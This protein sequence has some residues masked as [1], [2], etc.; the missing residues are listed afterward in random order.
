MHIESP[1]LLESVQKSQSF[2]PIGRAR[3]VRKAH[4]SLLEDEEWR[5][6]IFALN[7]VLNTAVFSNKSTMRLLGPGS[8]IFSHSGHL[9]T[10]GSLHLCCV[11][12]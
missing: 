8:E 3:S 11:Q 2:I 7:Q 9:L 6:S 5:N 1:G 10:N 12:F 4:S